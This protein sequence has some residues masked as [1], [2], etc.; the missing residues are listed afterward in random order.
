MPNSTDTAPESEGQDSWP[1]EI[2]IRPTIDKAIELL[3]IEY[4]GPPEGDDALVWK[5]GFEM[6][7]V[8]EIS[9]W[10]DFAIRFEGYEFANI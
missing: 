5:I 9:S 6:S 7:Q 2:V 4:E 8:A 10:D 3:G 1:R